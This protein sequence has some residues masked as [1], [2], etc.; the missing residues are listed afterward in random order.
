LGDHSFAKDHWCTQAAAELRSQHAR[1]ADLEAQLSAIAH[2]AEGATAQTETLRAELADETEA[3]DNWRRLA[4]QFDNHRM[5]A[6]GHLKAVVNPGAV[7]D[8]YKAAKAFLN[9]PPLDGEEVLA[10]RIAELAAAATQAQEDAL[11][12]ARLLY[13]TKDYDGFVHVK[14]DK[15]EFTLECMEEAGRSEPTIE[16]ELNGVRRLIDA[17][18]A[19]HAKQGEK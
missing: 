12:A 3:A 4:L 1:I 8:A 16:D 9:A 11:D 17:A 10:Q 14:R 2:T 13:A 6:L 15:Y 18:I 19:A 7:F 5:Q